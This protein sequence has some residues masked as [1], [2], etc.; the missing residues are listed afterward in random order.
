MWQ[1]GSAGEAAES[2]LF[3]AGKMALGE[4]AVLGGRSYRTFP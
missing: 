2:E 1:T 4:Y 3:R